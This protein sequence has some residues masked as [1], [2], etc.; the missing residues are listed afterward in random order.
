M[1]L[2]HSLLP[3]RSKIRIHRKAS[4]QVTI[5]ALSVTGHQSNPALPGEGVNGTDMRGRSAT[6]HSA[7][8]GA[9]DMLS[10]RCQAQTT[11]FLKKADL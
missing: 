7:G 5:E 1:D 11:E 10:Q 8:W 4:V 2:P 6:P 9:T 3:E